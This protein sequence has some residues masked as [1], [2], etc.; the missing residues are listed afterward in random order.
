M[1]CLATRDE[2]DCDQLNN[3]EGQLNIIENERLRGSLRVFG[4]AEIET[5]SRNLKSVVEEQVLSVAVSEEFN[6]IVE[7][8]HRVGKSNDNQS[9]LVI[10]KSKSP[11]D[12]Y[13]LFQYREV[14]RSHGVRISNVISYLQ[15]Q[16]LEDLNKRGFN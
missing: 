10:V 8:A 3:I 16:Q 15:R 14:L 6:D 13:M 11:D 5:E 1:A 9:R 4:L 12:K 7:E 2:I